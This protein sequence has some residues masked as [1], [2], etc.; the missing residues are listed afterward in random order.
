ML[1]DK[2]RLPIRDIL[3]YG[4]LPPPLK[5]G[6]YRLKGYRIGKNVTNR[7]RFSSSAA[8]MSG[9]ATT[10]ESGFCTA[11][12]GRRIRIGAHV[13]M[14]LWGNPLSTPRLLGD[15]DRHQDQRA[16][17]CRW[18]QFPIQSS[19]SAATARSADDIHQTLNIHPHRGMTGDRRGLL[20]FRSHI[21]GSEIRK[22][23]RWGLT[24]RNRASVSVAWR[25][26][27]LPGSRIRRWRRDRRKLLV[28][29]TVPPRCL[30]VG[31]PG[32]VVSKAPISYRVDG[33]RQAALP[34][35]IG[36]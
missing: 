5:N 18:L 3:I 35:R 32:R 10:A 28:H 17:V 30:A 21:S 22:A 36:G 24:H 12:R 19:S 16:G 14:R 1:T 13:Q 29:R 33:C 9:S 4:F 25:C 20:L 23:T 34:K 6:S 15:R 2:P 11:V 31:F 7:A 8:G 26:S 27:S